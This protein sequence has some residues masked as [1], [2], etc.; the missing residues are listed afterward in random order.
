[1]IDKLKE[2]II[3]DSSLELT[4]FQIDYLVKELDKID[5]WYEV[6]RNEVI[7]SIDDIYNDELYNGYKEKLDK[8][9][10]SDINRIAWKVY[11]EDVWED[12][13]DV[14]KDEI[15]SEIGVYE[16]DD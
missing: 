3:N 5:V 14:A 16:N 10:E 11:D 8:L 15:K 12:V 1:M 13:Y 7:T 9:S 4:P 2:Q 6:A